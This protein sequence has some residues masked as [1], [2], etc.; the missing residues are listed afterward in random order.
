MHGTNYNSPQ[1][2]WAAMALYS[3]DSATRSTRSKA[4]V[5]ALHSRYM[6]TELW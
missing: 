3:V 6:D 1:Q 5:V 4:A 2:R